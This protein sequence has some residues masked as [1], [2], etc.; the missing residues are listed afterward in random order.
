MTDRAVVCAPVSSH[1][2][3]MQMRVLS[4]TLL[5]AACTDAPITFDSVTAIEVSDGHLFWRRSDGAL[6]TSNLDGS[7]AALVSAS[8]VAACGLGDVHAV[9]ADVYWFDCASTL[10]RVRAGAVT[11]LALP[12]AIGFGFAVDA[13]NVYYATTSTVVAQPIDGTA[14]TTLATSHETLDP[15][16][17]EA[18]LDDH[19]YV[20]TGTA[21]SRVERDGSNLTQ[22]LARPSS[23]LLSALAVD[24]TGL[25]WSKSTPPNVSAFDLGTFRA[26]TD[27]TEV[28]WVGD[29]VAFSYGGNPLRIADG[30][31]FWATADH[32]LES[33]ALD[34]SDPRVHYRGELSK[35]LLIGPAI[36]NGHI[37]ALEGES[38]F[39]L[40]TVA[41]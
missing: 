7:E 2:H 29:P 8:S 36:A 3:G 26:N 10:R 28:T 27:G 38:A 18:A 15:F 22:L 1:N 30:R 9:G 24:A 21:I 6:F 4:I 17:I 32:Q 39:E 40:V 41:Y 25:F 37:Y 16:A 31:V 5:V 14:P 12:D 20:A 23:G 33:V 11:S 34:G 19:V 35:G 13:T